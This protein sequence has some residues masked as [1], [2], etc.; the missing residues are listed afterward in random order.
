MRK[1]QWSTLWLAMVLAMAFSQA[2]IVWAAGDDSRL[3]GKMEKALNEQ[4][5]AE[6]ASS[7]I[8]LSMAAYF[9]SENLEGLAHW[10]RVQTQEE[11]AHAMMFFG[12]I[13]ERKGRVKLTKID[14]PETE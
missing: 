7:Y 13:N 14:A 5:N 12:Y 9:E 3:D 1:V 8:Y 10:M 6:M 11:T 2:G 4:I